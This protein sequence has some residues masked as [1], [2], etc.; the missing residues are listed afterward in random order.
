VRF[1]FKKAP[2]PC[3]R[4]ARIRARVIYTRVVNTFEIQNNSLKKARNLEK[5]EVAKHQLI[6]VSMHK[7]TRLTPYFRKVI[8]E[9]WKCGTTVKDLAK[10]YNVSRTT[11][12]KIAERGKINDFTVH[13][14]KNKRYKTIFYGLKKLNK[15][16]KLTLEKLAKKSQ[17]YEKN[18]PG[19]M[20]HID[21]KTLAIRT[22]HQARIARRECLFVL[23]DDHSRYLIAD[24][25][26]RKNQENAMGFLKKAIQVTP[27]VIDCIYSDNGSE[28]K[29]TEYHDFAMICKRHGIDRKF[30]RPGRPQTNGKAERV[31]RVIMEECFNKKFETRQERKKA[32]RNYVKYYNQQRPHSALKIDNNKCSPCQKIKRF[33][34]EKM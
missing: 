34:D 13:T 11:I 10:R 12:Y 33:L 14:S 22:K 9:K 8:Y 5:T 23:I 32:L 16:E 7:N 2:S 19:E 17:R 4:K 31:I 20:M 6:K 25:L 15:T 18:Y 1:K 28:F 21:S 26:P 3:A 24:I 27:F 29:G 30:T